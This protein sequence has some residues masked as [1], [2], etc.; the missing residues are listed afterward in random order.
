MLGAYIG[1]TKSATVH[2]CCWRFNC[3]DLMHLYGEQSLLS[4]LSQCACPQ[5]MAPTPE[6]TNKPFIQ[7]T[8]D[9]RLIL[10]R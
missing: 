7:H 2:Q 8:H 1:D 5:T 3:Y 9:D 4:G 6:P 10:C